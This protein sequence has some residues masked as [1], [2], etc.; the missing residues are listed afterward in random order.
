MQLTPGPLRP[1]TPVRAEPECFLYIPRERKCPTFPSSVGI[2]L[3]ELMKVDEVRASII[4]QHLTPIDQ[5]YFI[6]VKMIMEGEAK[7]EIKY[8]PR[9]DRDDPEYMNLRMLTIL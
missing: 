6:Y 7:N 1:P 3:N 5:T 8:R 9:A 4:A 2:G